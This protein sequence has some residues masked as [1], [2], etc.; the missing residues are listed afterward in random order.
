[1]MGK[2]GQTLWDVHQGGHTGL[3]AVMECACGGI[4]ACS[5]C[6]VILDA[7]TFA[8]LPEPEEAELDILDLAEDVTPT[9]R[10]GCQLTMSP[11]LHGKTLTLP[12]T[13]N[14]LF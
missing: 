7:D 5:T 10:L 2:E 4:A 12:E 13:V 14:N 11:A 8:A 9:S 3:K 6:H 1:V